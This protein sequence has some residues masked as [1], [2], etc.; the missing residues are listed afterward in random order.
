[1]SMHSALCG[2]EHI[3]VLC[4]IDDVKKWKAANFGLNLLTKELFQ[5]CKA[6]QKKSTLTEWSIFQ[7]TYLS[8]IVNGFHYYEKQLGIRTDGSILCIIRETNGYIMSH[9]K[10][11]LQ[12]QK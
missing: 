1:M 7:W 2:W 11:A 12:S 10:Y 3:K 9:Y 4:H 6:I 5:T 8:T